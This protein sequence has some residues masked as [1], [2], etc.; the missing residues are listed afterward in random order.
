ME[1]YKLGEKRLKSL[2]I[3]VSKLREKL[4]E[5]ALHHD[6]GV[7]F[8]EGKDIHDVS[9]LAM[10]IRRGEYNDGAQRKKLLRPDFT[11]DV[12]IGSR[13]KS[14]KRGPLSINDK[15]GIVHRVLVGYEKLAEIAKEFRVST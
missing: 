5:L 11:D 9:R 14:K 7:A 2:G 10:R 1:Q 13:R 4:R 12:P 15:I 3:E 8:V 6:K